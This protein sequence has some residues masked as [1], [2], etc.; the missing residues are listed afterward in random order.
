MLFFILR[1]DYLKPQSIIFRFLVGSGTCKL[2]KEVSSSLN[3]GYLQIGVFMVKQQIFIYT[4]KAKIKEQ[5]LSKTVVVV[6][7]PKP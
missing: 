4:G 3:S 7:V 6:M 2:H 1:N 5:L